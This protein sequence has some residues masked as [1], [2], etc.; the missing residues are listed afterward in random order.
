[1]F[2]VADTR[3]VDADSDGGIVLFGRVDDPLQIAFVLYVSRIDADLGRSGLDG[4]Q[5]TCRG[6]MDI[7]H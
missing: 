7:R 1:M 6:K 4:F 2:E 3:F 5:G